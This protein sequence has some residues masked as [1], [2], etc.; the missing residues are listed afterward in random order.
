[1]MKKRHTK[2][3]ENKSMRKR[4][5]ISLDGKIASSLE[6]EAGRRGISFSQLVSQYLEHYIALRNRVFINLQKNFTQEELKK[7]REISQKILENPVSKESVLYELEK[8]KELYE[9]VKK[10]SECEINLLFSYLE[11]TY[12]VI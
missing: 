5:S 7:L 8:D 2:V 11:N 3:K 6:A 9:K 12:D 1:M 4:I 10:L